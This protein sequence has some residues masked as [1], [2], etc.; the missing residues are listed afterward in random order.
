M[1]DDRAFLYRMLPELHVLIQPWGWVLENVANCW[2]LG[3]WEICE[4][5]PSGLSRSWHEGLAE[6]S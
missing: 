4:S 1:D 2:Q 5:T 6:C 3:A